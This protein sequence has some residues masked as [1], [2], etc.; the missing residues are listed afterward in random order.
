MFSSSCE[1]GRLIGLWSIGTEKTKPLDVQT[2]KPS[3]ELCIGIV[4]RGD[5]R[6]TALENP[7]VDDCRS[8]LLFQKYNI[9]SATSFTTMHSA[10]GRGNRRDSE[11]TSPDQN[12]CTYEHRTL[13]LDHGCGFSPRGSPG[14]AFKSF[15]IFILLLEYLNNILFKILLA[16]LLNWLYID[17]LLLIY[18]FDLRKYYYQWKLLNN[19]YLLYL[20]SAL[21]LVI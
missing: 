11:P 3:V 13:M 21:M 4:N 18:W 1:R 16:I 15:L 20:Y 6:K 7:H 19:Y 2:K 12:S 5:G 14:R 8:S 9:I 10:N 17:L